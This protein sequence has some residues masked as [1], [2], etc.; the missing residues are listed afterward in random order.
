MTHEFTQL[1][2]VSPGARGC[3]SASSIPWPLNVFP[4]MSPPVVPSLISTFSERTSGPNTV[5][6]TWLE[7]LVSGAPFVQ[8]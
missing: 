5:C 6:S 1:G 8:A 7:S 4:A 3:A 2:S